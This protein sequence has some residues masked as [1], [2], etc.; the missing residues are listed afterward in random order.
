MRDRN[1]GND[2]R[3][4]AQDVF[5]IGVHY[6][7][8][9]R[10]WL[11]EKRHEMTGDERSGQHR[12]DEHRPTEHRSPPPPPGGPRHR[13]EPPRPHEHRAR[14][15]G[16]GPESYLDP[17]A[18]GSPGFVAPADTQRG[19]AGQ[20]Y[21]SQSGP[22]SAYGRSDYLQPGAAGGYAGIGPRSYRRSDERINEDLCER[23]THDHDVDASDIEVKV[24]E[25]IVTLSG[26]VRDRWMKHRAEDIAD[27]CNGV[28]S[29]ENRI[30]VQPSATGVGA[31]GS[32][33]VGSAG[34]S[35]STG[36]TGTYKG[37][38]STTNPAAASQTGSAA[39]GRDA[40]TGASGGATGSTG[41]SGSDTASSS[42]PGGGKPGV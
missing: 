40:G 5:D 36:S 11:D 42:G 39:G 17:G 37:H 29:V 12:S 15:G 8:S 25:G 33:G 30:R 32:S 1:I 4:M 19:T 14:R 27:G 38:G 35:A 16:G 26:S 2:F 24:A 20:D 3:A 22:G 41:S 10:E 28:H 9:G 23:L 21:W 18:T 6:V 34:S 31:A 7:R 13:H